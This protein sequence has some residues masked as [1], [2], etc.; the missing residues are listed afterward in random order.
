MRNCQDSCTSNK[1]K[2]CKYS[3]SALHGV[4][5]RDPEVHNNGF[6]K[7]KYSDSSVDNLTFILLDSGV[8]GVSGVDTST[9]V[10]LCSAT[11]VFDVAEDSQRA[12]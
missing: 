4:L 5:H 11:I 6:E 8:S 10:P 3:R 12:T 2:A 9:T 7:T 1:H